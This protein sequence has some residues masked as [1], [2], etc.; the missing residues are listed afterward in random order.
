MPFS[1]RGEQIASN[2]KDVAAEKSARRR[3]HRRSVA[4][5]PRPARFRPPGDA[6][7]R[8]PGAAA[9]RRPR[10][11]SNKRDGPQAVYRLGGVGKVIV[12]VAAGSCV[13]SDVDATSQL[14]DDPPA[15]RQPEAQ[16]APRLAAGKIGIENSGA[17]VGR[18]ARPI[19][20]DSNFHPLLRPRQPRRRRRAASQPDPPQGP[21]ARRAPGPPR[22]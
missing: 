11:L 9:K 3:W 12:N 21:L 13:R 22:H 14:G 16:P 18:N 1:C 20:A 7:S 5:L 19:V 10:R 4:I 15:L 2:C 6:Q 17:D 8:R